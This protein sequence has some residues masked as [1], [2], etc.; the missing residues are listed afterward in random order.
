MKSTDLTPAQCQAIRRRL[1]TTV[2]YLAKLE[3]LLS[4]ETAS[5]STQ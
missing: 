3:A 4:K 1:R 2:V 5:K